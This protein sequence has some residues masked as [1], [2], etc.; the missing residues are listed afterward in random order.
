M[1]KRIKIAMVANNLEL[2]GISSVIVN[3]CTHIDKEK[4]D[5]AVLVGAP[6]NPSNRKKC[7][8]AGAE[9][10]ELPSKRTDSKAFYKA[11]N[12]AL[13]GRDIDIFHVHG[14]GT[15]MSAEL[16]IAKHNHI[17]HRI[18]HS[19]NTTCGH[20]ELHKILRPAFDYLVTDA[21][22]CGEDAGHWLFPNRSFVVIPNGFDID[23][24]I[25][26]P[27]VRQDIRNEL[28][29]QDD[30]LV[31]GHIGRI[32]SQK[33]QK[34]LL[35]VFE[36]IAKENEKTR[37]LMVGIGPEYDEVK[38]MVSDSPY[39]DRITMYGE[40]MH[41]EKMYSAIDE[42]VFPSRY[43]GLPIT[44]LEA[45]INGLPCT[46][47]DVITD[48]VIINDNVKKEALSAGVSVW[49]NATLKNTKR[50]H[51]DYDKFAQFRIEDDVKKLEYEYFRI[52]GEEK[53]ANL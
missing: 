33:N 16:A 20:L 15:V 9:V 30:E 13:K 42:F 34:F 40:S 31:L 48:E 35:Q 6:I 27:E 12:V 11:L 50:C 21:F 44:L 45:Q 47:S 53:D 5:I 32:N 14:N 18:A 1:D 4:F 2:N 41:P 19:H 52:M 7:Q 23:K 8:D 25:F 22:A 37:L 29:I 10:I 24:F 38:Q 3:Y 26:D 28:G 17:K 39:K 46:V 49:K 51:T 36:Q 43:E